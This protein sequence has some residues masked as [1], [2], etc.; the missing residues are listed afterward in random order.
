MVLRLLGLLLLGLLLGGQTALADTAASRDSLDR[1]EEIL[2]LRLDDGS[3]S[4]E[5]VMPAILVSAQPRYEASQDWFAVRVIEVLQSAF[6]N[7]LRLCEA[8]MAPRAFVDDGLLVYQTGAVALD[9]VIR[10]DDQS[11][12]N[13][14]HARSAVW[15]EETTFGIAVRIVDL[16]TAR[17]LFAQNVDPFLVEDKNSKRTFTL[18]EE[19]ERRSQGRSISQSFFDLA[20]YPGQHISVDMTEQWGPTNKNLS[21]VTFS[22]IDPVV[23]V[24]AAHYRC[25]DLVNILVGAKVI[26]SLPTGVA[27]SFDDDVEVIDPLV[28]AVAVVRVPFGRSNYGVVATAST[29]GTFGLGISLMNVRFLPVIP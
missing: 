23:G 9:E 13:A 6:G 27:R 29:N 8:C 12:G 1:L 28:T 11:R 10:L 16:R 19:L 26:L 22:L 2:Q 25:V 17:V 15:V 20:L 4:V 18:S 7:G 3:L 21:G 24:G 5:D 14:P